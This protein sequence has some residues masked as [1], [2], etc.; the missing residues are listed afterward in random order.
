MFDK[1]YILDI[2]IINLSIVIVYSE[3]FDYRGILDD[4][5]EEHPHQNTTGFGS[6]FEFSVKPQ[7]GFKL[8]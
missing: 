2:V 5:V 6:R 4:A 7:S 3:K 8:F 1:I